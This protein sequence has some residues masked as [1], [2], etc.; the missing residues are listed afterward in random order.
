MKLEPEMLIKTNYSGPYRIKSVLRDCTCPSYLDEIN[1]RPT[2]RRP[3]I[4]LACTKP[5]GTGAFYINGWD[6]Q[7]LL[8]LQKS[9]CGGK[10]EIGYD[11]II[12]LQQDR[13]IQGTLF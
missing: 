6:E 7:T 12:V 11:Q 10:K 2:A 9:Y 13:P 1:G 5:D 4:H 3:H 8:S